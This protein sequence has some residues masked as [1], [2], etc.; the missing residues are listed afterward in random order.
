[1]KSTDKI[2]EK[3]VSELLDS[4]GIKRINKNLF[5]DINGKSINIKLSGNKLRDL[6]NWI[7]DYYYER[8][9]DCGK[10]WGKLEQLDELKKV[11]KI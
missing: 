8:G 4:I 5:V 6:L 10:D 7:Q 1:M 9:Y 2:N 11:L 3:I